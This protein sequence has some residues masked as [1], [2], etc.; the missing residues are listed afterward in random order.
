LNCAL[1]AHIV[2]EY[3][4]ATGRSFMKPSRSNSLAWSIESIVMTKQLCCCPHNFW[5]VQDR[6]VK[7]RIRNG[8][9]PDNPGNVIKVLDIMRTIHNCILTGQDGK[10]PAERRV[11]AKAPLSYEDIIHSASTDE[12]ISALQSV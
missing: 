3:L 11:L 2:R 1:E 6:G 4:N 10:T 5:Q 8:C 12:G 9:S 7:G